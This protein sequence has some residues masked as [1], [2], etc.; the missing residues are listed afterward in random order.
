MHPRFSWGSVVRP[1][2]RCEDNINMDLKETVCENERR[3]EPARGL[4]VSRGLVLPIANIRVLLPGSVLAI[5]SG[6]AEPPAV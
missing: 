5:N 4:V 2:V 6:L 1:S 3:M